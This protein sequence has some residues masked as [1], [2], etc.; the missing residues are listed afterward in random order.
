MFSTKYFYE[1]FNSKYNYTFS[2]FL[3][4][5]M[6]MVNSQETVKSYNTFKMN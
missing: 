2:K 4:A 3:C 6:G 5:P 1:K